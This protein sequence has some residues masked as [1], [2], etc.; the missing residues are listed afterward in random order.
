MENMETIFINVNEIAD[1][2]DGK[3]DNS[4]VKINLDINV[5]LLC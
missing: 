3:T 5:P 4:A 2:E 1:K